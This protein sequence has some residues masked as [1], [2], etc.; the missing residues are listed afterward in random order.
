MIPLSL[1]DDETTLYYKRNGTGV[2]LSA[3]LENIVVEKIG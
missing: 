2:T 1:S 3:S